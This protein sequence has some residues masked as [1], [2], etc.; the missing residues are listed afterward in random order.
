[1]SKFPT[2][3]HRLSAVASS[4]DHPPGTGSEAEATMAGRGSG[5]STSPDAPPKGTPG[6]ADP[7]HADAAEILLMLAP[8]VESPPPDKGPPPRQLHSPAEAGRPAESAWAGRGADM[9]MPPHP[10]KLASAARGAVQQPRHM[11][12]VR[13]DMLGFSP[14]KGMRTAGVARAPQHVPIN[15]AQFAAEELEHLEAAYHNRRR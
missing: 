7:Q 4:A 13:Q 11:G 12:M 5:P 3:L 9:Q 15:A 14:N 10:S 8:G 6:S 2:G 1:M